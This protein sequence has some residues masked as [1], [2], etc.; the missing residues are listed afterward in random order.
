MPAAES[1]PLDPSMITLDPGL[2]DLLPDFVRNRAVDIER[3]RAARLAGD[4]ATVRRICHGIK[5]CGGA[6]GFPRL[7]A[8]AADIGQMTRDGRLAETAPAI[9]SLGR[10][11]AAIGA[12]IGVE[13]R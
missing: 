11:V 7:S 8:L 2:A 1:S 5:G 4:E 3:L 12:A 13:A 6:F 10:L 9:E